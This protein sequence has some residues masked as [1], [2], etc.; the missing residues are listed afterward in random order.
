ML[1]YFLDFCAVL[2]TLACIRQ[3]QA[4][5]KQR[6]PFPSVPGPKGL[7]LLG[8]V[9]DMQ[10]GELWETARKWGEEFGPLVQVN[11]LGETYIFVNSYQAAVD[12]FE[13]RGSIYSS[14][15]GNVM[16]ELQGWRWFISIMQYGDELRRARQLLHR[17]LKPATVNDYTELQTQSARRMLRGLLVTPDK[18][19]ELLRQSAGETILLLT[20]GHKVQDEN[21]PYITIAEEGIAAVIEAEEFYLVNAIPALQYL[22]S[23]L[24]GTGFKKV[25]QHG[26]KA[27]T[28]LYHEPYK[29]G[30]AKVVE[31]NVTPSILSRLL[32]SYSA[33]DKVI[34]DEDMITKVTG[35]LYSAAADTT[36][37]AL[38]TFFLAMLLYPDVQ[39]RAQEELDRVLGKDTLPTFNDRPN[40]PYVNAVI[41]ESLR[42]QPATPVA[43]A[44]TADEDDEYN[45]YFIPAGAAV[46][47]NIW[48][49]QRD[50]KEY[51]EPDKFIP[52][53][54]LP[55]GG[56][57]GP[58]D[59]LK[60]YFG[61]GRRICPGRHF[62]DNTIFIG[63][64][65]I[66]AAF[67]ITNALDEN[68]LPVPPKAEFVPRFLRHPKPFK[69]V[70]EPRSE[71][72]KV[73][74]SETVEFEE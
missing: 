24:P 37:A 67:K 55:T 33:G 56:K 46:F 64:A 31:D 15:P 13:K 47:P 48:A 69:Y 51:P 52:D 1:Y 44:H 53:R 73:V 59:V 6:K 74:I 3:L 11:A 29:M 9:F 40:L 45:G 57:E 4:W 16:L 14:R 20:Y 68:G 42:W 65:S 63:G 60:T 35:V 49:M 61:F 39:K 19:P 10:E 43:P 2:C 54:W 71:K 27:S 22:P 21:D 25:I 30:K 58:R 23:W 50:Q 66:L 72:V 8:N 41:K 5:R 17:F 18:F 62:A 36:V 12:L 28:E 32:E 34:G 26:Q 38:Y 70:L 7:P